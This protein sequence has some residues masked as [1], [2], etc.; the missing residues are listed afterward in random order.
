MTGEVPQRIGELEIVRRIGA[1]GFGIVYLATDRRLGRKVAVKLAH[2]GRGD[3]WREAR[4]A[5]RLAHPNVVTIFEIGDHKGSPYI[6]MEYV[7]GPTLRERLAQGRLPLPE[8]LRIARELA[9]AVAAAHRESVVHLDLTPANV[10]LARD[11]RARVVDFGLA[12]APD[13]P[14]HDE[15]AGTPMF[16]APEQWR[17]ESPAAAADV[18]ALGVIVHL[19]VTGTSLL[20]GSTEVI[21]DR[22]AGAT[23]LELAGVLADA[24][25]ELAAIVRR[26]LR[27]DPKARPAAADIA[28]AL[29]AVIAD[30]QRLESGPFRGLE[31]FDA[32][33]VDFVGRDEATAAVLALVRRERAVA[34]SGPS[35]SGKSSLVHA[36]VI[37][38]LVAEGWKV[39]AV[40]PGRRPL[41]AIANALR[42]AIPGA[43]VETR[44][45]DA[46]GGHDIGAQVA[47]WSGSPGLFAADLADAASAV[48][49][50]L[51]VVIDQLEELE[52]MTDAAARDAAA[53]ALEAAIADDSTVRIITIV[54]ADFHA[55]LTA[56][57]GALGSVYALDRPTR[58][59]LTKM[60]EQPLAGAGLRVEDGLVTAIVDDIAGQPGVLVLLQW[61][62]VA[63][64]ERRDRE[65]RLVTRTAYDQLGGA[66]GVAADR[67]ASLAASCQPDDQDVM[68]AIVTRCAKGAVPRATA[69]ADLAS[70]CERVLEQLIGA[71]S[72][73]ARGDD[74][75][76]VHQ[77]LATRGRTVAWLDDR[78][79]PL[80][81]S[82]A[83]TRRRRVRRGAWLGVALGVVGAGSVGVLALR[84]KPASRSASAS[85]SSVE[86]DEGESQCAPFIYGRRKLEPVFNVVGLQDAVAGISHDGRSIVT[87]R[88]DCNDPEF[89]PLLIDE[90]GGAPVTIDLRTV[91]AFADAFHHDG[92][93]TISGDARTVI[94]VNAVRTA[95]VAAT[96]S[97]RGT[98][99]FVPTD[100]FAQLVVSAPAHVVHPAISPDGLA[101]YYTVRT[102]AD[103]KQ[104]GIYESLR[105]STAEPFPPG[106]LMGPVLQLNTEI[107][108]G[109]SNDRL[110]LFV[111]SGYGVSI[112]TRK[113]LTDEFHNPNHPIYPPTAPGFRTRPFANCT[114]LIGTCV[115]GCN[116][117]DSCVFSR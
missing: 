48:G 89:T 3:L 28:A 87:Y 51:V 58:G 106:T 9:A 35:A 16:M 64:W 13:G 36:G 29:D 92:Q 50:R 60:I 43:A 68:R 113:R 2:P 96:R 42:A 71:R 112:F 62:G 14:Q 10:L 108:T 23:E 75:A 110:A 49:D 115:T 81:L 79:R 39:A 19:L 101:F 46:D 99:D 67:L 4:A 47:R 30:A 104:N 78:S 109:I 32:T 114:K 55:R 27:K 72:V 65:R 102:S 31:P 61:I 107:V 8:A 54:R 57:V 84:D 15:K 116:N 17:G 94:A 38:A 40:R 103:P 86:E 18:W 88:R 26:C 21:R 5:A 52:T 91:R 70:G 22:V 24:P 73:I 20:D 95:F 93:M 83:M 76:L 59:E 80:A 100:L 1:G 111:Q 105:S 33:A 11:G 45:N 53:A 77:D 66:A 41:E 37:A 74:I 56:R 6:V 97:A 25:H 69:L 63:L 90:I 44:Q 98:A 117:E 7:D 85:T 12:R 82:P 34:I